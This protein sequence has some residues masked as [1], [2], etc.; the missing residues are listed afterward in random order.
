MCNLPQVCAPA[1]LINIRAFHGIGGR[2]RKRVFDTHHFPKHASRDMTGGRSGPGTFRRFRSAFPELQNSKH[3]MARAIH[4]GRVR[5]GPS[6]TVGNCSRSFQN[7]RFMPEQGRRR[8]CSGIRITAPGRPQENHQNKTEFPVGHRTEMELS[9]YHSCRQAM[10]QPKV[11]QV[12]P[13]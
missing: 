2:S 4:K 8:L 11:P 12:R 6:Q 1:S 10:A 9:K 5:P 7:H 13:T 3:R